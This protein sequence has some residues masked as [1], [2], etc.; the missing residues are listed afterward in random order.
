[1]EQESII[2][3]ENESICISQATNGENSQE[4]KIAIRELD[5]ETQT[6]EF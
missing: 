6:I 2:L 3:E 4:I 5:E 1:M